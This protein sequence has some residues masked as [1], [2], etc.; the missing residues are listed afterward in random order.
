MANADQNGGPYGV[1]W[2]SHTLV[3]M[4][5]TR[6]QLTVL[7]IALSWTASGCVTVH[8]SHLDGCLSARQSECSNVSIIFVESPVDLGQW[9]KLPEIVA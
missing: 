6:I 3:T 1:G 9:G 7:A 8:N 4:I 5:I 2:N